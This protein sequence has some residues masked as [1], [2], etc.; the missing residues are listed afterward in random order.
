MKKMISAMLAVLLC[1]SLSVCAFA[2]PDMDYVIDELDYLYAEELEALNKLAGEVY[3]QTNVGVFYVFTDTKELSGYD[4]NSLVGGLTDY[5]A[6]LENEEKWVVKT[7]GKGES[8]DDDAL[9]ALYEDAD[10]YSGAV[11]SIFGYLAN[12]YAAQA[13][14]QTPTEAPVEAPV[15]ATDEVAPDPMLVNDNADLLT[16]SEEQK[17][18]KTLETL[19]RK[20]NIQISVLT[21]SDTG[22]EDAGSFIENVYDFLEY[23]Y[24]SG[25]DGVL[26]MVSMDPRE[27]RILSNGTANNAIGES[28][29][30]DITGDIKSD[31]SDG[32][33]LDAFETYAEKCDYYIDGEK[34]GFP[35][36][37]G[38]NI[39]IALVV[40]V[41][42]GL[43]VAFVLK[44]QLKSVRR[45][46][47]A[48]VYVKPGTM[49]LTQSGDYFM[50]RTV[51]RT[52]RQQSNSSSSGS[53]RSVGGG[54][55]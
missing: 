22:G 3:D 5:V 27:F 20:H 37:F 36:D 46:D 14:V 23:G 4:I 19:S 13:P 54:S 40:G 32:N 2:A 21:V 44:G 49:H 45:Q 33:Y 38:K 29:I 26:L 6:V 50:Y 1:M 53:S 55:F 7:G 47:K 28:E 52:E 8:V 43:I 48:N 34:N 51:S 11:A 31:L 17:L 18:Y 42:A 10:T 25:H 16:S 9:W 39:L 12:E 41:V 15:E 24:G 30:E 35:F